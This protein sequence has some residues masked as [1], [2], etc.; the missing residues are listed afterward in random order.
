MN[1]LKKIKRKVISRIKKH[2]R[3]VKL[4]NTVRN[5]I[6]KIIYRKLF[7]HT[8]IDERKIIFC[9][10]L[11]RNYSCN[12]KALYEYMLKN[13][14]F[15]DYEFI[16]AFGDKDKYSIDRG[17]KVK[18]GS[19]KYLYYLSKCKYWIFNAKMPGFYI[20]KPGQIY[21]QTW[22][23]TPLKKLGLDINVGEDATFYRNKISR[24][25]MVQT[26]INDSM[27]YDYFISANKFSTKA[28][29]TAFNIKEDIIIETGYP[30]N[31]E[32]VNADK[33]YVEA[34]KDK[35][36]IPKDKVIILYAPT[37][38]DNKYTQDG[39]FQELNVDFRKWYEKLG[40]K[41][42]IIYKPH[43]LISNTKNMY[44]NPNFIYDASEHED[45]NC[46]YIISDMLITD[47]SSVFF[48]YAALK[49]PILF[50]MYDLEEYKN[51][52]R[53]FYLDIYED[54][55]APII[56]DEEELLNSILNIEE[57]EINSK[58]KYDRFYDR[59]CAL[60]DGKSSEKVL[61]ILVK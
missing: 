1:L 37:W 42:Y 14:K 30:R 24:E 29:S 32:I 31:D 53:G 57:V 61:R 25:Q 51:N 34:L 39:Y 43:Y 33:K 60:N 45:I 36:N 52:L 48:D 17:I 10:H 8:R 55:P 2:K 13:H 54:L 46:L 5:R 56:E 27:K 3:F 50:Y 18:Y 58:E 15:D 16:W 21:L 47:Y 38:R 41:Y 12:P 9:S 49:R 6:K 19:L 28:F 11:G 40:D 23:G 26:Y 4:A 59:F 7:V 35:L 22:H 44:M 20:K